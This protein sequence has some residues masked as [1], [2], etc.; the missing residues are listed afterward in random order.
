MSHDPTTAGNEPERPHDSGVGGRSWPAGSQQSSAESNLQIQPPSFAFE[1]VPTRAQTQLSRVEAVPRLTAI[2]APP[3]YGKTVLL[4]E[5][6][7]SI[8]GAGR[9]ALWLTLDDRD[10]DLSALE[11]RIRAALQHAGLELPAA[12]TGPQAAFHGQ[13][14]QIDALVSL[15]VQ[16]DEPTVVFIDNLGF[17]TDPALGPFLE[18][19]IFGHAAP[20]SLVLSSTV[21]MPI[22]MARAKLE[23]GAIEMTARHMSFDRDSAAAVLTR[24]GIVE[25]TSADV[26]RIVAQ[27]EGWPAAVRLVQVLLTSELSITQTPATTVDVVSGL[28][29]F[30]GVHG[31]MARMLTHR[32]LGGFQA[33]VVQF[34]VELSLVRDFNAELAAHMT[35]RAE[36][37][38]WLEMLVA[39]N[40]LIF[41]VDSRRRWFRFHTLMREFL[42]AEAEERV[43][44]PR[45][46]QL[47]E[48]AAIWHRERLDAAT[49]IEL[50]LSAGATSLAE[51]L[52]DQIAQV[53][54][55][56]N[57]QMNTF[58]QW[59]DQLVQSGGHPTIEAQ[60][61][62]VW[63]LC[64]S[65]QYERAR[66]ALDD[67]DRQVASSKA[68]G[69]FEELP[70]RLLFVR[71]M[72]NVFLDRLDA[73]LEGASVLL[74]RDD[75]NDPFTT[76][77]V[78]GIAAAA[79][80][81]RSE[82]ATARA[83]L[84]QG[85]S[86]IDRSQSAYGLAW[87]C[88]LQ[89][90][91]ELEQARPAVAD[92]LLEEGR[93]RVAQG[94]GKDASIVR[95]LDFVHARALL[96]L[97]RIAEAR[98][99]SLRGLSGAARHGIMA[100]LE[101]GFAACV[102][103]WRE[104]GRTDID[105]NLLERTAS[106][107]PPRGRLL[108]AAS[109]V[110]RLLE[111]GLVEEAASE[112]HRV[113]LTGQT[114]LAGVSTMRDRSE[115]LLARLELLVAQG[116][117][118]TVLSS[119]DVLLKAARADGRERDRVELLLIAADAE[120]QAGHCRQ[121]LRHYSTAL[122]FAAPGKL[123]YPFIRRANLWNRLFGRRDIKDLNLVQPQERLLFDRLRALLDHTDAAPAASAPEA[124]GADGLTARQIQLLGLLDEGLSNEQ[125]ADR[126]SLSVTTVKWHLHNAY[127]ALGVRSR[128]AAL[129]RARA[130]KLLGR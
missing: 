69:G 10:S 83:H 27:T 33:D 49:A 15:L 129:A 122:S 45:R 91:L 92:A 108:L 114:T 36:A 61:W 52:L 107:Y 101:L 44:P 94:L 63:A 78:L 130:L 88:A 38:N 40:V 117:R 8:A 118:E 89:A 95:T 4:A 109:K 22:D 112:A 93:A 74:K 7:R 9:R 1:V 30:G 82:L 2:T 24:A 115:W 105:D 13:D 19:L 3:G 86:A 5:L 79:E 46:R 64:D 34:M 55:R 128:S 25:V 58:I 6:F 59:M 111:L 12:M 26:D 35:G 72:A 28:Q 42:L 53:V 51:E 41:P 57:G 37:R 21:E 85:R 120:E 47:L 98:D 39:R 125:V 16:V 104:H 84:Q 75:S 71:I 110:R 81:D 121:A 99:R 123:A 17:C 23:A 56:D 62:F 106:S 76:A 102:A 77:A 43:S 67:L 14:S 113:G 20:L 124:E 50:A 73:A 65:L 60:T 103:L 54:V 127:V 100:T 70:S 29:H 80:I 66:Q 87:M 116:A 68:R 18:R 126:L 97:G 31:D 90:F 96:D 48:R 11:F 119:I 32:V